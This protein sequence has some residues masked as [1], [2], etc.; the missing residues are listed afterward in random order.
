VRGVCPATADCNKVTQDGE[1]ESEDAQFCI[2]DVPYPNMGRGD[3]KFEEA[4]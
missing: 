3:I 1:G 4:A 2:S